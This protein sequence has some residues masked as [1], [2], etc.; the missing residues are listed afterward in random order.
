MSLWYA[1][2][3]SVLLCLQ[4]VA[5]QSHW[6]EVTSNASRLAVAILMTRISHNEPCSTTLDGTLLLYSRHLMPHTPTDLFVFTLSEHLEITKACLLNLTKANPNIMVVPI[7]KHH[8]MVPEHV[9]N[10]SLWH[11]EGFDEAYRS[12]DGITPLFDL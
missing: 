11:A 5:A 7:P 3:T 12:V 9:T 10:R 2:I 6:P 8:W 1:F 4:V